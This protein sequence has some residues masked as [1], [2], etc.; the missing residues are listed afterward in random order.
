MS[1]GY[2]KWKYTE[3]LIADGNSAAWEPDYFYHINGRHIIQKV[4][5]LELGWKEV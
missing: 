2:K 4:V 3:T 5:V 1:S